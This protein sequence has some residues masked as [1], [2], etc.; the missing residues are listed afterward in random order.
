MIE[1]IIPT[2][3][4]L[5]NIDLSFLWV[6]IA[7]LSTHEPISSRITPPIFRSAVTAFRQH[8]P[9]VTHISWRPKGDLDPNNEQFWEVSDQLTDLIL[10]SNIPPNAVILV[11]EGSPNPLYLLGKTKHD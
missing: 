3:T 7:N 5:S 10:G 6:I 9:D 4:E 1:R 8:F 2:Q 11:L